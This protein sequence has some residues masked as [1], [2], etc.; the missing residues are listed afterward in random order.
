MGEVFINRI[1]GGGTPTEFS[2]P[3]Q[4]LTESTTWTCP[5]TGTYF[6][7]CIG[8]GG[9]GA[10]A[11]NEQ[12]SVLASGGSGG[13]AE[14][15]LSLHKG[16][17]Y[18]VTVNS[19][20]TSFGNK[21]SATA[22]ANGKITRKDYDGFFEYP[23]S[24]ARGGAG[25]GGDQNYPGEKGNFL[26]DF[27]GK[28]GQISGGSTSASAK[29]GGAKGGTVSFSPCTII[30]DGDVSYYPVGCA[31]EPYQP[32]YNNLSPFGAGG[33]HVVASPGWLYSGENKINMTHSPNGAIIIELL[34]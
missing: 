14:S 12:Y 16:E 27:S 5:K 34:K 13:I 24:Q 7:S 15:T 33:G 26:S 21:L 19:G 31:A 9:N 3:L 10:I 8:S 2:N 6:I 4:I 1:S 28:S 22:G 11:F 29:Y 23:E 32:I 30:D 18:V 17:S 20:T 25:S